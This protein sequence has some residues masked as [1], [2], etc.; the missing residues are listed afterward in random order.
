MRSALILTRP[1][2]TPSPAGEP[3]SPG[4]LVGDRKGDSKDF[5]KVAV[6]MLDGEGYLIYGDSLLAKCSL[7]L[8]TFVPLNKFVQFQSLWFNFSLFWL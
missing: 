3:V 1:M 8:S 6:S 5:L 2:R 7:I 4:S